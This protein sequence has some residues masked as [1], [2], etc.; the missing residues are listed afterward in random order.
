MSCNDI[1]LL[2][3][4]YYPWSGENYY[5]LNQGVTRP[6]GIYTLLLDVPDGYKNST[7]PGP[8]NPNWDG[9]FQ[10]ENIIRSIKTNKVDA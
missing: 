4:G 7:P 3:L 2:I 1:T 6:E 10:F 5:A 9:P 8:G